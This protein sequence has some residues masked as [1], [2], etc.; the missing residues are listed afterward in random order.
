MLTRAGNAVLNLE[1]N[2]VTD[3]G[4]SFQGRMQASRPLQKSR[5]GRA[6]GTLVDV[7]YFC[8]RLVVSLMLAFWACDALSVVW[9]LFAQCAVWT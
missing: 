8:Y 6:A 5:K 7:R 4:R 9:L 3:K 2:G 1:V